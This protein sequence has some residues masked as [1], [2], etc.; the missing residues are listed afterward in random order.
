MRENSEPLSPF[1]PSGDDCR[2]LVFVRPIDEPS[3]RGL[4]KRMK[5]F[6]KTGEGTERLDDKQFSALHGGGQIA[7]YLLWNRRF[8]AEMKAVNGHPSERITRLIQDELR[9]EPRM[10]VMGSVGVQRIL[11]DR[12]NGEEINR[13]MVNI[14]GRPVRKLLRQA[15]PQLAATR[16]KLQLP[17][18]AG[19]AIILIDRP[20]KIEASVVAYAVREALRAEER[21]LEQIDFVWVSIETHTVRLPDGRLG[22]PELGIWR[23]NRR[24]ESDRA[25]MGQMMDAWAAFNGVEME[26]L[27]HTLGW[28]TLTPIGDGWPLALDLH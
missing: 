18:A 14:G 15:N 16:A 24:P 25:M 8:I 21:S 19:L 13:V 7:D 23:A 4:E 22:Y 5:A 28:E 17:E 11:S 20:Q 6:F 1:M 9:K 26:H 10:F 3:A 12:E 2:I 27:D